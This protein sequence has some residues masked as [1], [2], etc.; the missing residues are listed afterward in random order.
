MVYLYLNHHSLSLAWDSN[1]YISDDLRPIAWI[2]ISVKFL[3][4]TPIIGALSQF[5]INRK[6]RKPIICTSFL[7]RFDTLL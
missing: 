2:C 3:R 7:F 6:A 5:I 1:C 4:L